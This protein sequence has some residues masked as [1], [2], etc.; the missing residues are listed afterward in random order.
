MN[1]QTDQSL[2]KLVNF[3]VSNHGYSLVQ[4]Q[5]IK[6]EIWLTNP[7]NSAFPIIRLSPTTV[8]TTFFEKDRIN[9]IYRTIAKIHQIDQKLLD[10]HTKVAE[11]EEY[12]EDF[13][14]VSMNEKTSIPEIISKAFSD[15]KVAFSMPS[16]PQEIKAKLDEKKQKPKVKP[17][18]ELIP[19]VTLTFLAITVA[20]FVAFTLLSNKFDDPVALSIILGSYYKV[21]IVANHEYWRFLTAGFVHIE[22]FHLFVNSI[23]LLNLGMI[24]ERIFGKAKFTI[25]LLVSIVMGSWF[26]YIGQG[27]MVL[28]GSSG[29]LYG[30]MGA[31]L[32]YTFESGAIKQPVI[33]SQFIRILLINA[34]ISLLPGISLLGH[35][36]GFVAGIMLAIYFSV[37]PKWKDI[38]KHSLIA[39]GILMFILGALTSIDNN[40]RPFYLITDQRVL[41]YARDLNLNWYA[42]RMEVKLFEF[43]GRQ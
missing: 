7:E 23:A 26:V 21:F 35:L 28:V 41:N 25:I 33:R 31:L 38:R 29:G 42:D 9:L 1:K 37:S 8:N 39:F 32:V 27:N 22:F 2:W 19:P 11:N 20:V 5:G 16:S 18:Y 34:M 10:I 17:F 14:Q 24:T 15:I 3:F 30:L 43:Y 6:D 4:V 12:D 36:G 40:V 13:I